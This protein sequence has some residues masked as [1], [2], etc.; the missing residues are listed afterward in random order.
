[1]S[2]AGYRSGDTYH[3]F[4]SHIDQIF[5]RPAE[6][7]AAQK[8]DAAGPEK[9]ESQRE[10][11]VSAGR[12]RRAR[13]QPKRYRVSEVGSL[14]AATREL[15]SAVPSALLSTSPVQTSTNQFAS[16]CRLQCNSSTHQ[17]WYI[18]CAVP[19]YPTPPTGPARRLPCLGLTARLIS[20]VMLLSPPPPCPRGSRTLELF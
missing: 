18:R 4:E 15:Q 13:S 2:L 19:T 7:L 3:G 1:V 16:G 20:P 6:F 8:Y 10:V 9:T 17:P 12:H 11:K 14:S 5:K